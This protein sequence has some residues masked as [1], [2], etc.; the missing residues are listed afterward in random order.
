MKNKLRIVMRLKNLLMY[1]KRLPQAMGGE[2]TLAH[3]ELA[4]K[5]IKADGTVVDYGI[6]CKRKVTEAFVLDLV[7]TLAAS[8]DQTNFINFKYHDCGTGTTAE[9]NNQTALVTP[10]GGSRATGTQV[11][12]G[13]A[14]ARTYQSVGTISFT[15]TLAIT[16]HGLFNATTSGTMMDRSV[17]SA[18][19]VVSGDSIQF[20][21]TL[22]V[23]TEA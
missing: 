11:E 14:D 8:G 16:E 13:T 12:G 19:N 10:Y 6:V 15:S 20:T 17:F 9:D 23:N 3:S 5:H 22:T 7:G 4:I 1:L 18:V 2:L 21:Y